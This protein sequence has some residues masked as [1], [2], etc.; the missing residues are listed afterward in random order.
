MACTSM[1]LKSVNGT[2]PAL[3]NRKVTGNRAA[4]R[5]QTRPQRLA[6]E[7]RF[8]FGKTKTPPPPEPTSLDKAKELFAN[9]LVSKGMWSVALGIALATDA[10]FIDPDEWI[11][12]V[13]M[14]PDVVPVIQEK[15]Q[16]VAAV[17][18]ICLAGVA[19]FCKD[20]ELDTSTTL[21]SLGK[22]AAIGPLAFAEVAL[23]D[24]EQLTR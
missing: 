20:K 9:P 15:L 4:S 5:L 14:S 7:A 21:K 22:T 1:S 18:A 19:Y 3:P 2:R 12:N 17:H 6:V 8:G 24:K 13:G 23:L 16:Q 10:A 11:K